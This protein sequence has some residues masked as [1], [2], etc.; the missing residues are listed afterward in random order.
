MGGQVDVQQ[1]RAGVGDPAGHLAAG[2]A[3]HEPVELDHQAGLL[4]Q[5]DELGRGDQATVRPRP[6]DQR[7]GP[8]HPTVV[9]VDD[10]LVV[11]HQLL[12]LDRALQG[13][14]HVVAVAHRAQHGGLEHLVGALAAALGGVHGDVGVAQQ[15]GLVEGE[16]LVDGDPDAG[17]DGDLPADQRERRPEGGDHPVGEQ[18]GGGQVG[19]LGQDG[20][21]VAAEPADGVVLAQAAAQPAGDL[22][23]QPVAGAVAEA[24]VDHL[25]VVQVDEQHGQAAAV[26]ARPGQ[27]VADPVVEQGPVGQVGEAVV[28]HLVLELGGQGVALGE[29]GPQHTLGATQLAHGGLVLADQVGH[30]D[31]HE[32]KQQR[33]AGDD[34]RDVEALVAQRLDGRDGRGHQRGRGQA[35][36]PDLGQPRPGRRDRVG[37]GGDRRVEHG[38]APQGVG[39]QPAGLDRAGRV[40]GAEQDQQG[41]DPQRRVRHVHIG[42]G[43]HTAPAKVVPPQHRPHRL[44]P[45]VHGQVVRWSGLQT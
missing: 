20:E 24:V 37:E 40:V 39:D 1:Q 19:V 17:P 14:L 23:Q 36:Q 28:E 30:A 33:A 13:G 29:R 27:R 32:Q 26:A 44:L 38:R 2:L 3:Q 42:E 11:D 4:G 43:E 41:P 31:Q 18:A 5:G 22:A 21:L 8:G 45:E 35:G 10:R 9:E 34:H 12:A 6:A 15:L 7:L 16:A 25:E